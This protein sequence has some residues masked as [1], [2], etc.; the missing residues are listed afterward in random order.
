MQSFKGINVKKWNL[1]SDRTYP[2]DSESKCTD[3]ILIDPMGSVRE[4]DDF[5]S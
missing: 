5:E 3:P 4:G 1:K 2:I